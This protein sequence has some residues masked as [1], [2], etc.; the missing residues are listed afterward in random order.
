LYVEI[1][2]L[3]LTALKKPNRYKNLHGSHSQ[4]LQLSISFSTPQA[5]TISYAPDAIA[6]LAYQFKKRS[7]IDLLNKLLSLRFVACKKK[8]SCCSSG[9]NSSTANG[10]DI[11][12]E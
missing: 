8:T 12:K 2:E 4:Y 10:L 11:K 3:F 1:V 9:V 5:R 7:Q 6:K